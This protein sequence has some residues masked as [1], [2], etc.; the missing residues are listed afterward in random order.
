MKN[1]I[2]NLIR[3]WINADGHGDIEVEQEYYFYGDWI[4]RKNKLSMD[5]IKVRRIDVN[6]YG[7]RFAVYYHS[8]WEYTMKESE[9]RR[10][11]KLKK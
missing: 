1:K 6:D 9:F 11:F 3:R 4:D 7:T 8:G 5:I 10:L 2:L